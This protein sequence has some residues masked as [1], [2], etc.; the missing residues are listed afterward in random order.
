MS[1]SFW[2]DHHSLFY[3]HAFLTTGEV[4]GVDVPIMSMPFVASFASAT[5]RMS[6]SY[7]R[8]FSLT[9][10]LEV[11]GERLQTLTFL[12]PKRSWMEA[13]SPVAT[14]PPPTSPRFSDP[15]LARYLAETPP[16]AP[17]RMSVW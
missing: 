12:S 15:F 16:A 14:N 4:A 5:A 3:T 9:N 2:S 11:S 13:R 7:L 6:R 17:V 8:L 1:E 10:L